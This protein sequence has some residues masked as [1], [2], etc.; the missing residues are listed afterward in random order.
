MDF[1]AIVIGSGFGGAITACRLAEGGARVL[2]LERGRRWDKTTYPRDEHDAWIWSQ[3]RP[4][5]LNG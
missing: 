2:V 5:R 3:S 4:E 1:D